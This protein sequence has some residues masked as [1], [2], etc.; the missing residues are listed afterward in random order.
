MEDLDELI[1]LQLRNINRDAGQF[2][3]DMLN[4]KITQDEQISFAHR[5]VD[6][7]EAI[8]ERAIDDDRAAPDTADF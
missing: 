4:N 8:R 6:L 5:L 2:A 3:T 7:A 1:L